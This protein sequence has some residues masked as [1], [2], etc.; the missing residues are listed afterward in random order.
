MLLREYFDTMFLKDIVQ[1]FY[2]VKPQQCIDLY[3]YL[4]SNIGRPHTLKSAYEFLK[5]GGHA[6]SRD[7]V[8]D[9]VAWAEDAWL[10]FTIPIHSQSQKEQERI[11]TQSQPAAGA[12]ALGATS[13]FVSVF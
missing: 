1:R 9:Y 2:F 5:Q 3:H 7:A 8:R 10:L 11:R 13:F 12:P 4:L 6:T